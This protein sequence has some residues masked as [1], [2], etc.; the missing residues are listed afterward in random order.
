MKP[1]ITIRVWSGT[2]LFLWKEAEMDGASLQEDGYSDHVGD[3]EPFVNITP[4][5]AKKRRVDDSL[6]KDALT[7]FQ[8]FAHET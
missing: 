7:V 1:N 4:S 8:F 5:P 2:Y 3:G 6:Q